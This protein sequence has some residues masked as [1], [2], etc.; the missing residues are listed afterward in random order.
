MP[1][2]FTQKKVS[3][4]IL[5][6]IA[7]AG[8]CTAIFAISLKKGMHVDEYYSYGLSNYMGDAIYMSVDLGFTYDNP[9][10]PFWDYMTVQK[11]QGFSYGNVWAKQSADVHPP[12][13]YV[14]LHTICSLFPGKFSIWFAAVINL[15]FFLG[16]IILTYSTMLLL[17]KQRYAALAAAF[18]CALSGGFIQINTFLRMYSMLMFLTALLSW[19]HIKYYRRQNLQFFILYPVIILSGILTHYYFFIFLF[20]QGMY[21]GISLLVRKRWKHAAIYLIETVAAAGLAILIFPAMI[22]HI[23]SGYRGKQSLENLSATSGYLKGLSDF[24]QIICKNLTG[25]VL[26]VILFLFIGLFIYKVLLKREKTEIFRN[27]W[28]LLFVPTVGYYLLVSKIGVYHYDRY[29]SPIYP[30]LVLLISGMIHFIANNVFKNKKTRL[31]MTAFVC[32][33]CISLSYFGCDWVYLQEQTGKAIEATKIYSGSDCIVINNGV[34]FWNHT[35]YYEVQ[36]YNSLTFLSSDNLGI[37]KNSEA[38]H[39]NPVV[40]YIMNIVE[41]HDSVLDNLMEINTSYSNA[42]YITDSNFA[43]VYLLE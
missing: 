30:A 42:K 22:G 9:Q 21:F 13:Y 41:N 15:V 18:L 12:F 34:N 25:N 40:V 26:Y 38:F 19:L 35:L 37:Y 39:Q 24:F 5:F 7:A 2:K 27:P 1:A 14:I 6:F 20:M 33:A 11:E 17:T 43:K 4:F 16:L 31:C 10:E 29:I 32:I 36:D 8:I 28:G 3:L 23:F